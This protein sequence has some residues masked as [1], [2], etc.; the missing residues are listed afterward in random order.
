M[1]HLIKM[2]RYLMLYLLST[3]RMPCCKLGPVFPA[4]RGTPV[5]SYIGYQF[6]HAGMP[7]LNLGLGLGV[8]VRI[9]LG[10]GLRFSEPSC[11]KVD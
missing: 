6:R 8:R 4:R 5:K 2:K 9:G 1:L 10:L 7:T 3:G 11:D